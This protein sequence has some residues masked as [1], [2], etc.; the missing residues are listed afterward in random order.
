[1][2]RENVELVV[3]TLRG[4]KALSMVGYADRAEALE[5]VGIPG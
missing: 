5:A 4:R 2:S 1:M 3:W